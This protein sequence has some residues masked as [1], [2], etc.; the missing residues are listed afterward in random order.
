LTGYT[1]AAGA[2]GTV[3]FTSTQERGGDVSNLTDISTLTGDN[4]NKVAVGIAVV[5]GTKTYASTENFNLQTGVSDKGGAV[6]TP[7]N[8]VTDAN[9][10]TLRLGAT[11]Q[12]SSEYRIMLDGVQDL[13]GNL[14]GSTDANGNFVPAARVFLTTTDTTG[15]DLR[16]W[17]VQSIVS[18]VAT[19]RP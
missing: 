14:A 7:N 12:Q 17:N 2:T 16:A 4:A 5:D 10:Y 18:N 11:F 8:Q 3:V 1:V 19:D 15:P 13:S 6:I 9:A